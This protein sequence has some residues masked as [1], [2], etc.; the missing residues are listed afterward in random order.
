M[1]TAQ[2]IFQPEELP[3][4]LKAYF[5]RKDSRKHH[6]LWHYVRVV[7][8]IIPDD[9]QAELASAQF[10]PPRLRGE[11]LSGLDF[12][13]MH[14]QMIL[15]AQ[16]RKTE[17]GPLPAGW[18]EIPFDPNDPEW[19]MPPT[20]DGIPEPSWKEP[21]ATAKFKKEASQFPT[22]PA[23]S[24][25]S[26]AHRIYQEMSLDYLGRRI[27]NGIHDWMHIHWSSAPTAQ[28]I[29]SLENDWLASPYSS[30]INVRFWKIHGWIN[31]RVND[32]A[33]ANGVSDVDALLK[34]AF[35]G[36]DMSNGVMPSM[37]EMTPQEIQDS[38]GVFVVS[39]NSANRSS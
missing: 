39:R 9:R 36:P 37:I 26:P 23:N 21:A 18:T 38:E 17:L 5:G 35:V 19:P 32:W 3:P 25:S 24:L 1:A 12:I 28:D 6:A 4:K 8:P 11:F 15:D 10:Q 27:E 31:D 22:L 2:S 13:A 33:K 16:N 14:R 29:N 7:W 34:N 30:H 20:Y